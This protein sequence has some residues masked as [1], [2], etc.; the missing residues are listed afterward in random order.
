MV[1]K[2]NIH[3]VLLFKLVS[4]FIEMCINL[5]ALFIEYIGTVSFHSSFI[6]FIFIFISLMAS[7]NLILISIS[8]NL[9]N[10]IIIGNEKIPTIRNEYSINN[11]QF[12]SMA[13]FLFL[14]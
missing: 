1:H 8:Y 5:L 12:G 6:R 7:L 11:C 10:I 4:S 14:M 9:S 2:F 13:I 3:T